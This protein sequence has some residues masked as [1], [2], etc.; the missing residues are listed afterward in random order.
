MSSS[1][2]NNTK[3]TKNN[4]NGFDLTKYSPEDLV[5]LEKI[6]KGLTQNGVGNA[7]SRRKRTDNYTVEEY[8]NNFKD[9]RS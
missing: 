5:T 7:A 3:K 1:S 9:E 4:N 8:L 6:I 2:I